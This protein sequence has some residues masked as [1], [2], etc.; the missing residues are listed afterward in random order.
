MFYSKLSNL[1]IICQ[2]ALSEMC[3]IKQGEETVSQEELPRKCIFH[4]V[5][6]LRTVF[7][8][9]PVISNGNK[10]RCNL[11][12]SLLVLTFKDSEIPNQSFHSLT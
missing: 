8:I 5:T 10:K 2:L 6:Q 3:A 9:F 4:K 1:N 11:S 12:L 7:G